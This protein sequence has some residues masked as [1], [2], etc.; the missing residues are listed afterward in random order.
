[1][2]AV[3]VNPSREP[4][5]GVPLV[6][7]L[8]RSLREAG[9]TDVTVL[10]EG[11][12]GHAE[13]GTDGGAADADADDAAGLLYL[14][15]SHYVDDRIVQAVVDNPGTYLCVDDPGDA[16]PRPGDA[17]G[18]IPVAASAG[19]VDSVGAGGDAAWVG[20]ARL[21]VLARHAGAG[22][23]SNEQTGG[24]SSD[25][26]AAGPSRD[27]DQRGGGGAVATADRGTAALPDVG[28]PWTAPADFLDTV[29]RDRQVGTLDLGL[30]DPYVTKLRRSVPLHWHRVTDAESRRRAERAVVDRSKKS[31]ADLL[32]TY[33]HDPIED[34][35]VIRLANT[36][37]TP[38]QVT[39]VVN[40][41]A[42]AATALFATGYLLPA[43]LLT[44]V[45]G[46]TDGFDGKL[47]RLTEAKTR[48]GATE[49]SFDLLYEFS[50]IVALAYA[51]AGGGNARP[52]LLAGV[53][54]TVVAFYRDFYDR[55]RDLTGQSID[56][57]GP[58]MERFQLVTGRRNIYNLHILAFVLLGRPVI[59][60]YTIA[61]HAV[62]T[63]TVY[64]VRG[65]TD[66][67]R[68]DAD[69]E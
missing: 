19:T 65:L 25:G 40:A 24:G 30:L 67:R 54:V 61:G 53:I 15:G 8:V 56:V 46:L 33:V 10:G 34:W 11:A 58:F 17:G 47:A 68:L 12:D 31:P 51:L 26:R 29:A 49:H 64:A 55:Y 3:V 13:P 22:D 60:L 6:E 62:L 57:A 39:L 36:S 16:R 43:S 1:M 4:I 23:P 59:A 27:R 28:A 41:V 52:L 32:A 7:R 20:I 66:L 21:D 63:A 45:V 42:Y 69:A 38:N 18:P 35:A 2:R 14:D 9:V 50:W 48:I 37:V 44:F 5:C